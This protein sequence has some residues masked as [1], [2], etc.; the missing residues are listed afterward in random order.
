VPSLA[1][2][3]HRVLS[4]FGRSYTQAAER[5]MQQ[6]PVF[7]PSSENYYRYPELTYSAANDFPHLLADFSRLMGHLPLPAPVSPSEFAGHT[8]HTS[9]RD[10]FE[11]YGSDKGRHDYYHVYGHILSAGRC[12]KKRTLEIGLGTNNPALVSTMGASGSPGAS[13]R[14]LRDYLPEAEIYGADID[15]EILFEETRIKTFVVDQLDPSSFDELAA[16]FGSAEFD[17]VID[18]GLHSPSA[19]INTLSFGIRSVRVGGWVVIEDIAERSL[20]AWEAIN[21]VLDHSKHEVHLIKAIN[22]YMFL[23]KRVA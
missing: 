6:F 8:D 23:V 4:L 1:G 12:E 3:K 5:L 20:P 21:A 10:L 7:V 9:L 22:A 17:L 11:R 18:D 2:L 13:L 19:N 14:A 15:P 16:Q